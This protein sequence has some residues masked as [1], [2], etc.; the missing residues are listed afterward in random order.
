MGLAVQLPLGHHE[1]AADGI[2][3]LL[4]VEVP[5]GVEGAQDHPVGMPRQRRAVVEVEVRLRREFQR[6]QTRRRHHA[7]R[8]HLRL[9]HLRPVGIQR[10]GLEPD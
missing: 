7:G 4:Q 3:R 1:A 6:R 10:R 2:V 9:Q 8:A 5:G